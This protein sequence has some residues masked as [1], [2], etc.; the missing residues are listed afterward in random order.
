MLARR[1]AN[2]NDAFFSPALCR[3]RRLKQIAL[4]QS[5]AKQLEHEGYEVF[6]PTVVCDRVAVMNGNVYFV[7]FKKN[8]QLLRP[9]QARIQSLV[10]YNYLVIY[11][12]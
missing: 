1:Y 8:G 3:A 11:H 7:E 2:P 9:G 5:Q 4:E 6:S 10:P 12:D